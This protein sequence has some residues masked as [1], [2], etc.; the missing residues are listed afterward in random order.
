MNWFDFLSWINSLSNRVRQIFM[1]VAQKNWF[2]N[3][4]LIKKIFKNY[5]FHCANQLSLDFFAWAHLINSKYYFK[6]RLPVRRKR[7]EG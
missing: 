2:L 4:T 6:P 1:A 5:L 3:T 7:G